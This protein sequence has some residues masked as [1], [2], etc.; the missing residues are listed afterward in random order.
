MA[1]GL[2]QVAERRPV[3]RAAAV[4]DV[5][6]AGGIGR[7]EFDHDLATGADPAPAVGRTLRRNCLDARKPSVTREPEIDEPRACDFSAGHERALRQRGNDG[8]REFARIL[9]RGLRE[10][11]GDIAGEVAMFLVARALDHDL[12]RI[13]RIAQNAGNK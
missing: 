7:H 1:G 13:D 5:H 8:L 4:P 11:H 2:E 10:A 9:A 3:G 6:G 12:G